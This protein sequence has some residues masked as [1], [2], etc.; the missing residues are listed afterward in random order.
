MRLLMDVL[1]MLFVSTV[2]LVVLFT[3]WLFKRTP[4]D[5]ACGGEMFRTITLRAS[6]DAAHHVP[7]WVCRRC[8]AV[9]EIHSYGLRNGSLLG[10]RRP[11]H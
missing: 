4:P 9:I 2:C 10:G 6:G 11:V 3:D 5:C 1:L 7:C 8:G